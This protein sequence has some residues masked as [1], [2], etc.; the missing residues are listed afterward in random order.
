MAELGF[1]VGGG[2]ANPFLV[3]LLG[4][5]WQKLKI[6]DEFGIDVEAISALGIGGLGLFLHWR[7]WEYGRWVFEAGKGAS[8]AYA[9]HIGRQVG[10]RLALPESTETPTP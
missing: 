5:D 4:P 2:F 6:T 8:A 1:A 7:D 9:G 10:A 3:S